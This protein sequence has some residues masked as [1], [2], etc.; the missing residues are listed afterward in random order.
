MNIFVIV[1]PV[2]GNG[3]GKE[4]F[5]AFCRPVFEKEGHHVDV[6]YTSRPND[7]KDIVQQLDISKYNRIVCA[8]GDGIL[9]E[10]ANGLLSRNDY[11]HHRTPVA[12]IPMG[13]GNALTSSLLGPKNGNNIELAC[14][15]ALFGEPKTLDVMQVILEKLNEKQEKLYSVIG[16]TYGIISDADIGTDFLRCLGTIRFTLGALW[17]IVSRKKYT[18]TLT[19]NEKTRTTPLKLFSCGKTTRLS[20]D[21]FI[22]PLAKMNDGLMDM[23]IIGY[24]NLSTMQCL[25]I[26]KQI[27][28][29]DHI[30]SDKVTYEKITEYK[31]MFDQEESVAID[32]EVRKC[33]S[34]STKVSDKNIYII[35]L[36]NEFM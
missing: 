16:Q 12:I 33:T 29:G 5:D 19:Y 21:T 35:T 8:S 30:N 31:L 24:E 18:A 4:L 36:S 1:N 20:T 22:N 9:H 27:E 3:F 14:R 15:H 10:V 32:G 28:T 11:D 17:S 26:M 25:Q 13:S 23:N 2:S 7:A 34:L 6:V